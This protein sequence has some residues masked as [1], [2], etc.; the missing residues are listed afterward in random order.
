MK[1]LHVLIDVRG[2]W[3]GPVRSVKE[4]V[5]MQRK[6]GFEPTVLSLDRAGKAEEFEGAASVLTFAPSFPERF[7]NSNLAIQWLREHAQEFDLVIVSEI[8][9]FLN[10][11]AMSVL[12]G[13]K[14]PY[15]VQPRGSLDPSDLRKKG[16]LKKIL[17]ALIVRRN[18][19]GANCILT[20]SR[21]E[22]TRLESFGAR[23]TRKTLP[24]AVESSVLGD[25][26]STRAEMGIAAESVVFIFLSRVDPKK[27][28]DVLIEGFSKAGIADAKMWIVGSGDEQLVRKLKKTASETPKPESIDFLGFQAGERKRNLL[29]GADVFVLPSDFENFGIAV[30][31]ALQ[32]GLPVII[33]RGV[34]LWQEIVEAGA[35]IAVESGDAAG[36]SEAMRLL[37]NSAEK[38]EEMGKRAREMGQRFLPEHLYQVYDG[39]WRSCARDKAVALPSQT[40]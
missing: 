4:L 6:L 12:R 31:E 18:L 8:W 40:E 17:G 25:R 21:L 27:R 3:G 14:I 33:S 39:F 29:A 9:S 13:M 16:L 11:R 15:I 30:V 35:G 28:V 32:A 5:K 2:T 10:Q 22:E 20:A 24:H 23:V 38:R 1:I 19:E 36:L 37:A 34:Q 26:E 7:G